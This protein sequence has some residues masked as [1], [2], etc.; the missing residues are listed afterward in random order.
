MSGIVGIIHSNGESVD[1]DLLL[2]MTHVLSFRGPDVQRIWIEGAIGL[3]HAAHLIGGDPAR[4]LQPES[5]RKDTWITADVRLDARE[6]LVAALVARGRRASIS[7]SDS[8]LLLEAYDVWGEHCVENLLGDFSF[9]LW[10]ARRQEL[11]CACDP[12][13]IRQLYFSQIGSCFVFSN[14]IDCLR[15]HPQISDRLNDTAMCDFLLFGVN[16]EEGTTSFADI[17]RLPRAHWL[18]WS[19]SSVTIQEYWHPP[20]NGETRYKRRGDYI[21]HFN[22]LLAK[23]VADR[24]HAD[25]VG[26]LLSGGLDSS[27]VAAVCQETRTRSGQPGELHAFT[28][29]SEDPR[30]HDRRAARAVAS[31]LRIPHHCLIADM[32]VP[33]DGWDV[34]DGRMPEP[35]DDPFA[36][37]MFAQ[38][39]EIAKRTPVILSGEGADNLMDCE[40]WQHLQR[41]W[42]QG[43]RKQAVF[44]TA[45]HVVARFRAPDGVRGPLRRIYGSFLHQ[46]PTASLPEWLRPSLVE[47]LNLRERW[48]NPS[49][50]AR[51]DHPQHPR[52]YASLF[53]P[54]WRYMFE[55]EDAGWTRTAV[56][57]RYPFLDLRLVAY[58]LAIP[59]M[60]WFFRK[61]LLREAMRGRLPEKI[62][63]RRKIT[64][65]R[66]TLGDALRTW[67]KFDFSKDSLS[68]EIRRYVDLD[69]LSPPSASRGS[70]M[71]ETNLRVWCLNFWIEGARKGD[72]FSAAPNLRN[73]WTASCG[74]TAEFIA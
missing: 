25:S 73:E 14:T 16:Q 63:K 59:P 40:P 20:T 68:D 8:R 1:R 19:S 3:G 61:F 57:V 66:D 31:A 2:Q 48:L 33:F 22:E 13:G 45:D 7:C 6:E 64:G 30:E 67:G 69:K 35:I 72:A 43:Q 15:L 29:T 70:E 18:R 54:Q 47:R 21:E 32:R 74:R 60:P 10:D 11:F 5:L 12:F 71:A 38:F 41:L 17:Q 23:A 26:V 55:R 4:G 51:N 44:A 28:M 62:R 52:G 36:S 37:Y 49:Q 53:F 9:A 24:I 27:S 58:L 50:A 34:D 65:G 46:R 42:R 56:E 39:T